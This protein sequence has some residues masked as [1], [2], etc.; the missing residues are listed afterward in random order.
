MLGMGHARQSGS[1]L[2]MLAFLF[3]SYYK[4]FCVSHSPSSFWEAT[5]TIVS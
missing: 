2:E 5:P 3:S 1:S 4:T